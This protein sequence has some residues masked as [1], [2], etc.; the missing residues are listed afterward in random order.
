MDM[1][2]LK[3]GYKTVACIGCLIFLNASL[4]AQKK[5]DGGAG[6][7]LWEN[8]MNWNDDV[9]P[10]ST[11]FVV[12]DNSIVPGNYDVILSGTSGAASC[13]SL[14]IAPSST[15][16][17]RLIIPPSNILPVAMATSGSGYTIVLQS[18]AVLINSSG[19]SSG[20]VL[21]ISDS[22]RI[23]NNG[24]YIHRTP[25]ANAAIMNVISASA[26]TELGVVEFDVPVVS[27]S[28][29]VA[30]TNRTFGSLV[31]SATA[32]NA[33]LT[34]ASNG[35][36]KVL[37]RGD[38]H[39]NPRVTFT[40]GFDDTIRVKG[41]FYHDGNILNLSNNGNPT[42]LL[43]E[44]NANS[45]VNSTITETNV[46]RPVIMLGGSAV[47]DIHLQ[48]SITNEIVFKLRKNGRA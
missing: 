6:D 46:G 19:A 33:A 44:G 39:I 11:D 32:N 42:V 23:E 2:L 3:W 13:R 22:M 37:I 5:W 12:I 38:L 4:Y 29:I 25:R 45:S 16:V 18:G 9:V 21:M 20:A 15:N 31:F 35:S 27:G 17:I 14:I 36:N 26:G 48:G 24:R 10:G 30:L 41:N 47:Q 34:Y 7:G 28:Y 40:V 1:D 8:P 43:L